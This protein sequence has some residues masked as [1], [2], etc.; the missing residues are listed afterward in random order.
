M[1]FWIDT[2]GYTDRDREMFVCGVEFQMIY[3]AVL[4]GK[5]WNQCIHTEN[6]SRVRLMCGK[7]RIPVTIA[8]YDDTWSH[9]EI[10]GVS[11]KEG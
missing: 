4:D 7:L 5:G 11:N 3:Q 6:E 2:E 9:C 1:P 8:R 10:P